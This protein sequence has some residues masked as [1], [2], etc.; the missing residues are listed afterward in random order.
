[1]STIRNI[2]GSTILEVVSSGRCTGC[3]TCVS[4]C[5]QNAITL[6]ID[7]EAGSYIPEVDTEKCSSCRVC[8]KVCPGFSLDDTALKEKY[9]DEV[10]PVALLGDYVFC[11]IGH[12]ADD[13]IRY[14]A[15]SGGLIT[16]LLVF[17]LENGIIEGA[18]VTR[19][20]RSDPLVPEPFIARRKEEIIE[21]ATSK[22]CPVPLNLL[23]SALNEVQEEKIAVVGLPCHIR[24][25]KKACG[26]RSVINRKIVLYFGLVCSHTDSFKGTGFILNKIGRGDKPLEVS[27]RGNGWP[28]SIRVTYSG[29]EARVPWE[30]PLWRVF[31]DSLFFAPQACFYCSD[32]VAEQADLSFGDAWLPEIIKAERKGESILI[33]RTEKGR[34]LVDT[35]LASGIV[36]LKPLDPWDVV[37]SQKIFFHFKKINILVRDAR[38]KKDQVSI[39]RGNKLIAWM[40]KFSRLW[41]TSI[42]GRFILS[43]LPISIPDFYV[44]IFYKVYSSVILRDFNRLIQKKGLNVLVLHAHWNNRGDEAAVRAMVDSLR[45]AL[46]INKIS[47]M[48]MTKTGNTYPDDQVE[49]LNLYPGS[50]LEYLDALVTCLTCGKISFTS[51]GKRFLSGIDKA[52]FVI[53]APGGPSIGDLYGGRLGDLPYLYR[54]LLAKIIKGKPLF[55]YAPSMGPFLEKR[56]NCLRLLLLKRTDK[57]IVRER[58]S[59]SYLKEQL[60]LDAC[61]TVDAA[62]QNEISVSYLERYEGLTSLLDELCRNKYVGMVV[63]D[64]KWHPVYK[65]NLQVGQKVINSFK[66]LAETLTGK[67]YKILLIPQ[68]F[69]DDSDYHLLEE[70]AAVN[71]RNMIILSPE[72][73]AYAQQVLISKLF[74]MISSRYHPVIFATKAGIPSISVYYEHKTKGFLEIA[75]LS[76]YGIDVRDVTPEQLY[77]LFSLIEKDYSQIRKQL[78]LV[79][80]SLREK[81]SHTTSLI[82]QSLRDRGLLT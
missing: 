41:G 33:C 78:L 44:R 43:K 10:E 59:A 14:N 3:G 30:T 77:N 21:A 18:L 81:A 16:Q 76:K 48:L 22:Y 70:L 73:D 54:L 37:R 34:S 65:H 49:V 39:S 13:N 62:L 36:Y 25:I 40:V 7:P 79:R 35:A 11:S 57:I 69:G 42:I 50:K 45:T 6:Q 72:V 20:R 27:Y 61:V 19:M 64:L 31:H 23:L 82:V 56:W 55:F 53:H 47:I 52:D 75:G 38:H 71:K 63:T 51:S 66:E 67:G 28:G 58:I 12:A 80:S 68:L 24:A 8:R 60:G 1:M 46:P 74:C 17:A 26:L 2:F 9:I 15:A 5:P 32:L 29:K 4:L